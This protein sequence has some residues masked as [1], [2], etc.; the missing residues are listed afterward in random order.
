MGEWFDKGRED[1]LAGKKPD[2]PHGGGLEGILDFLPTAGSNEDE[3]EE[4]MEGYN[5]V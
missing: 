5:S 4:Y 1:A 2:P 3:N